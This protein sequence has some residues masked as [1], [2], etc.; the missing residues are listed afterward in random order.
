MMSKDMRTSDD[1]F[2]PFIWYKIRMCPIKPLTGTIKSLKQMN[3]TIQSGG[4]LSR[5]V[6]CVRS[7]CH[8]AENLIHM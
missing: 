2:V 6:M 4:A 5:V 8:L 3:K 7:T 1:R